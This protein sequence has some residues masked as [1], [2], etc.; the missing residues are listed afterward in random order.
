MLFTKTIR[1]KLILGYTAVLLV[2]LV[3]VFVYVYIQ[4]N[5]AFITTSREYIKKELS[6]TI[7]LLKDRENSPSAIANFLSKKTV[8]FQSVYNINY[9]LFDAEGL[10]LA[11][12]ENFSADLQAV[13]MSNAESNQIIYEKHIKT[14]QGQR[15]FFA[16]QAFTDTAG[17]KFYLQF[18]LE[19]RAHPESVNIVLKTLFRTLPVIL[20]I[21]ISGGLFLTGKVLAPL[22]LVTKAARELPLMGREKLLPLSGTGDELDQLTAAFNNVVKQL[23]EAYQRI[24]TFT[25]DV[26]HELRLPITAM[27]GEA[28]VVLERERSLKE[29]QRVLGSSIEDMDRLMNMLKR[30]LSL[31]RADSGIDYLVKEEVDLKELLEKL[32]EFYL[33]LAENKELSLSVSSPSDECVLNADPLRLQELFSNL[34][35]NAVKYTPGKGKITISIIKTEKQHQVLVE[36]TGIGIAPEEQK[37]IFDRFYRVDKSRS[38]TDGGSGLGLSIAKMIASTHD[39]EIYVESSLNKGSCFKVVL[40]RRN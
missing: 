1:G 5:R 10:M 16:T 19:T 26:S 3:I 39:G 13:S 14:P 34:I 7:R 22:A 24:V 28:E 2:S 36:D 25:A 38:R 15:M 17:E 35:E 29:Y 23:R 8:L 30:L 6:A 4:L 40:P 31:T 9:A 27:K 12:S 20:I 21:V 32:A 37:K 33:P 18:G 11:R